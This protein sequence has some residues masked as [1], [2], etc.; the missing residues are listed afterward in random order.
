M[1]KK[2]RTARKTMDSKRLA[3]MVTTETANAIDELGELIKASRNQQSRV[4]DND[5]IFYAV[6]V[7][8]KALKAREE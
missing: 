7:A 6:S 5:A 1:A 2:A 3:K 8:I 4:S